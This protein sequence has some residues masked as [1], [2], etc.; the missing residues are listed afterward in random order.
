MTGRIISL[1]GDAHNDVN[2]LLPWYASGRLDADDLARVEAHLAGCAQC[3]ADLAVEKR[4]CA[5][6]AALPEDDVPSVDAGWAALNGRLKPRRPRLLE[7]MDGLRRQ[8][9]LSAGWL[10]VA[11]VA[12]LVVICG[13]L[14]LWGAWGLQKPAQSLGEPQYHTLSSAPV[15]VQGNAVLVFRPDITEAELR[16]TLR[17]AHARLVDG[18]T[19]A[20][21]YL[22]AIPAAERDKTVVRLRASKAVVLAEA[23]DT[24]AAP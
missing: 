5:A 6:V 22:V 24:K 1:H 13:G 11:A 3:Q 9:R 14:G 10:R 17:G 2:A 20:D 12:Q 4:L 19:A 23:I 15:A 7:Q 18:P 21:A 8:W 16:A